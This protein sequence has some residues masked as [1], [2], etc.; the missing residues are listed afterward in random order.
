AALGFRRSRYK[1]LPFLVPR[2]LAL[3]LAKLSMFLMLPVLELTTTVL[4]M[5]IMATTMVSHWAHHVMSSMRYILA[6]V[7]I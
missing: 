4:A 6:S 2:V 3:V 7:A 5:L 1:S